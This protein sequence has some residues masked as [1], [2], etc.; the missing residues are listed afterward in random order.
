L[1]GG[2]FTT[3]SPGSAALGLTASLRRFLSLVGQEWLLK[4]KKL[5]SLELGQNI[6]MTVKAFSKQQSKVFQY[7]SLKGL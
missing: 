2:F 3:E 5:P 6:P 4:R 1:A 7:D